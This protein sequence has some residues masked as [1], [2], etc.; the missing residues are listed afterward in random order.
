M[1]RG[2]AGRA[3]FLD[4]G[5][6]L[7]GGEERRQNYKK[8][9]W[10]KD[11]LARISRHL[12]AAKKDLVH[13]MR[14]LDGN[15]GKSLSTI[16]QL[17]LELERQCRDYQRLE[18][19]AELL[20]RLLAART[21]GLIDLD[22][23]KRPVPKSLRFKRAKTVADLVALEQEIAAEIRSRTDAPDAGTKETP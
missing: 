16:R 22:R 15:G 11:Y 21:L 2:P 3:G 19:K 14:L 18:R 7:K 20:T 23:P 17:R 5:S 12:D 13:L 6:H 1:P 8:F 10:R 4:T 9:R